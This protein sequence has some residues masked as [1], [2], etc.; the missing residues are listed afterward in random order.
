MIHFW[1]Y[2]AEAHSMCMPCF[3][4]EHS[5]RLLFAYSNVMKYQDSNKLEA[6]NLSRINKGLHAEALEQILPTCPA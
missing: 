5:N 6:L 2:C 1:R 3:V 4:V